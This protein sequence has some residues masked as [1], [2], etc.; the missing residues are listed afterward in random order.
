MF[1]RFC[2]V[3]IFI[4]SCGGAN[5]ATIYVSKL[6][7]NSDGSSWQKAFT[8]IQRA[9]DAVPDDKGGHRIVIRPDTYME[10]NLY[11]SFKGAKDNYNT[12]ETDYFGKEGSG[13]SGYA[14]ID[15]SDPKK[16]LQSVDWW[17][18]FKAN[19]DYSGIVWDRWVVKHLYTTGGDAGLFWDLPPKVE[20][21][22][23]VVEDSVGIGRAFG[24][25]AAHFL[26]RVDEPIVF[27]RCQLWCLDWWGDAAGAYVRAENEAMPERPDIYFEDC[28]LVGPDNAL[29]SGNPGFTTYSRI[30]LKGSRLISLNF[31]QPRGTPGTGIIYASIDGKLMHVDLEDCT[32]MGYKVFGAKEGEMTYSTAGS[33]R[34]YVQY[35]QA[36]PKGIT[37]LGAWPVETFQS[38]VPPIPPLIVRV[39][40]LSSHSVPRL[41]KETIE[42]PN[43]V[44]VSPVFWKGRPALLEGV[45][46]ASGGESKDH[47][48]ELRDLESREVLATFGE[49]YGLPCAFVHDD[50][51]Y[52]FASRNEN[53]DWND[54]T[55]FWSKDLK[56]WQQKVVIQQ[57]N[58]HLFNSSVC[59]GPD[60]FVMAYES[61]DSKYT[62][63]SVKFATSKDLMTWTKVPNSVF[64]EDRY[65]ACPCI[66]YANGY[67]YMIYL[68]H[69]TPRWTFESYIARSEDL[70]N[71]QLGDANPVLT[72]NL[73]DEGVNASD[74]DILEWDGKTY[75]YYNVGDQMTWGKVKRAVY[76]GPA[77]ELFA[78]YFWD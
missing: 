12:I 31:S 37:A 30:K 15:S 60:G 42:I 72:A 7:D 69:R 14:V 74:V 53:K 29:Q 49:G 71:W 45:R 22:T 73:D 48:L 9:L 66:R 26:A 27:R 35:E 23:V 6:G 39:N 24:G 5:A 65:T 41:T 61:N 76:E 56:E 32:L 77:R 62:P 55:M 50:T 8:T 33:V 70:V 3:V 46:P 20:P 67:Y 10:A 58:E 52:A 25:G 40:Q 17:S 28:T 57:E 34:A 19:P 63:F 68:E 4:F 51:F 16:G 43:M 54:V 38:I 18:P 2:V 21:F 78:S 47:Y 64:G 13:V 11:P 1:A 75:F 59:A 36:M 44:E